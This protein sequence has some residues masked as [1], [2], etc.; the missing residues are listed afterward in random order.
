MSILVEGRRL[1]VPG[2]DT[3][4]PWWVGPDTAGRWHVTL[5]PDKPNA[6]SRALTDAVCGQK[7]PT[8]YSDPRYGTW[9]SWK[10][11]QSQPPP[12]AA[13]CA[14]CLYTAQQH[15]WPRPA[16]LVAFSQPSMARR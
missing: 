2:T 6:E 15:D 11:Q 16:G 1:Y 7:P 14:D 10:W 13:C 12:G 8:R 4:W 3:P 5:A 9:W